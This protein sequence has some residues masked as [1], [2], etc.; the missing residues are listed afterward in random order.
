MDH[1]KKLNTTALLKGAA[2]T[3][4][5]NAIVNGGI[6]Y[7]LLKKH[8]PIPITVDSITNNVHTVLG[9]AVPL[10]IC[11]AMII[12]VVSYYKIKGPKIAFFPTIFWMVI[13]HGFFT[14]GVVTALAV[15]WQRIVGTVEVG[16]FPAVIIIG[17]IAGL[18]SGVIEYSTIKGGTADVL[19]DASPQSL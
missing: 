6:Q 17:I 7:F 16:L 19:S 8:A 1:A 18:I 9:A 10:A 15:V 14:F 13:K 2:I 5:I 3:G 11:L 4:L 12:T